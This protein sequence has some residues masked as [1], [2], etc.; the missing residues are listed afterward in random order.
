MRVTS[1]NLR[2]IEDK[3]NIKAYATIIL[4]DCLAIHGIK[5]IKGKERDFIAFPNEKGKDGK[6]YDHVHPIVSSLRDEI[7]TAILQ[8]YNN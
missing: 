4:D 5:L 3:G 8:K 7:E 2:K 6:Y 1:V